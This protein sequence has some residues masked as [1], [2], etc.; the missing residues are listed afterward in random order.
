MWSSMDLVQ[1]IYLH[2]LM[3]ITGHSYYNNSKKQIILTVTLPKID[4]GQ[5]IYKEK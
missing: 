2:I 4:R 3:K 5:K 1:H